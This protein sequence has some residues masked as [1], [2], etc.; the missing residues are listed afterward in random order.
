MCMGSQYKNR[1]PCASR[2][3]QTE[4]VYFPSLLLYLSLRNIIRSIIT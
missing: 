1:L 3:L 2:I 4:G